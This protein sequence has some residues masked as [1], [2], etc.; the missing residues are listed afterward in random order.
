MLSSV[1]LKKSILPA[2]RLGYIT[3]HTLTVDRPDH[4]DR[5]E[6]FLSASAGSGMEDPVWMVQRCTRLGPGFPRE[7]LVIVIR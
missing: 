6:K 5:C 2:S 4:P 1:L 3:A 7:V